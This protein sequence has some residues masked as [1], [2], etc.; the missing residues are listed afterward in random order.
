MHEVPGLYPEVAEFAERLVAA[1]FH[2]V[3]P[4]MFGRFGK[5]FSNAY[6]AQQIV[7]ACISRP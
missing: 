6:A 2:A 4:D 1:G 7:R 5:P 3:L